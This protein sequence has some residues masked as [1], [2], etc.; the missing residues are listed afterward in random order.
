MPLRVLLITSRMKLTAVA[1]GIKNSPGNSTSA[2]DCEKLLIKRQVSSSRKELGRTLAF[3]SNILI[4]FLS[5]KIR[6]CS[7]SEFG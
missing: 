5:L 4:H 3:A 7:L 1:F 2:V 6:V